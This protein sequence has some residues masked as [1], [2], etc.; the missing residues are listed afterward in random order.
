MWIRLSVY[1]LEL[2]ESGG[3][4]KGF[5][6]LADSLIYPGVFSRDSFYFFGVESKMDY[7]HFKML[8]SQE[9]KFCNRSENKSVHLYS[10]PLLRNP[11]P[12][13]T[14][15]DTISTKKRFSHYAA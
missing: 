10:A 1:I 11:R 4:R 3:S 7:I 2:V 13:N 12:R 8:I 9:N 5:K 6:Q 14:F 15:L